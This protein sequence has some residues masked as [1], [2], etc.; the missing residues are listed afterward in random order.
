MDAVLQPQVLYHHLLYYL[1]VVLL[2]LA[3]DLDDLP[4]YVLLALAVLQVRPRL[5][6]LTGQ[7]HD[8][9]VLLF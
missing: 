6:Q 2:L 9:R 8:A 3:A 4:L 1:L 7:Y 5:H